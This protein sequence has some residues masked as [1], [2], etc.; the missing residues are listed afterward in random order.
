MRRACLSRTSDA[1]APE[2]TPRLLVGE[3]DRQRHPDPRQDR[4]S[5]FLESTR[6]G[7]WS[8]ASASAL[9][10]DAS[11]PLKA[12]ARARPTGWT[13]RKS[14]EPPAIG[15]AEERSV[16]EALARR[17][18]PGLQKGS[19]GGVGIDACLWAIGIVSV[20]ASSVAIGA[21]GRDRIRGKAQARAALGRRSPSASSH[22]AGQLTPSTSAVAA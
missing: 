4:A 2:P 5:A 13:K 10:V 7:L 17:R 20:Q 16:A 15:S 19:P 6:P 1:T 8:P 21:G 3:L 18:P 11:L 9:P 12:K 22:A 14:G